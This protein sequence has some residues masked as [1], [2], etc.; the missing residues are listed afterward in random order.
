VRDVLLTGQVSNSLLARHGGEERKC[1]RD[2]GWWL[3]DLWQGGSYASLGRVITATPSPSFYTPERRL[4]PPPAL[5][6]VYFGQRL[7]DI[8]L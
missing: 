8:N 4:L 1:I 5:A 6:T 3:L 2:F 7:K